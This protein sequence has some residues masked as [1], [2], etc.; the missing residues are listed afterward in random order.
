MVA[1]EVGGASEQS[2]GGR[3]AGSVALVTGAS[4]GLGLALASAVLASDPGAR[5]AAASRFPQRSKGL[6][7]LREQYGERLR[8]FALD[9]TDEATIAAAVQRLAEWT[10]RLH[11]V[12][13]VAGVLHDESGLAPVPPS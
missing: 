8:L 5:V 12:L 6:E 3:L 10:P 11:R 1:A 4:R 13:N 7:Q 9:V 2:G